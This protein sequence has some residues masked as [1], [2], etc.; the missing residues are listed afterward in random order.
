MDP[1]TPK[2]PLISDA[3][4]SE[5]VVTEFNPKRL[6]FARRR[7]GYKKS[8]L[9]E[10]SRVHIRSITAF[11]SAEFSPS[12]ET[13]ERLANTLEF[14][15]E[16]FG[17]DDIDEPSLE[18]GSFR[19]MSK[20]TARQRDM[21]LCQAAIGL[22]LSNWLEAKFELP[23]SDLPDL[24]REPDPEAAAGSL[25]RAWLLGVLPIRN[26]VHLLESKGIRVFSLSLDAREVDAFSMWKGKTPY[27]FLNT[28]KTS[29][30][31]R[32]DAVHELGHLVLHR[33]GSPHGR[34]AETQAN[35]FAGA[36]LMP[37]ASVLASAPKFPVY[38]T[39]VKL[40]KQ[41]GVS[42]AALT[43]RLHELRLIT[44]WQYRGLAIEISKYGRN[45]EPESMPRE[46]SLILPMMLGLLYK[47]GTT[48]NAIARALAIST[49]ELD[50]LLLGLAMT[51]I[52]GGGG[53]KDQSRAELLR[54]K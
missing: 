29:E 12:P 5:A 8:E 7:R 34:E 36:F 13:L 23:T 22:M 48:R 47:E 49:K 52:D 3:A 41:W 20:M 28:Q 15:Q 6:T 33:D 39:L 2:L 35:R 16:F 17:G 54:V 11:E 38:G 37:R 30:H 32:Y 21:A 27:V 10:L 51:G 31:A 42:V 53:R 46:A 14:P 50:H 1:K 26:V 43:Y 19:S 4:P 40:K 44:D 45:K 24:S 18:T 9:A 25:R